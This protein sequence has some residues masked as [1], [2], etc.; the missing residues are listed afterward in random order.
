MRSSFASGGGL[1]LTKTP[2]VRQLA[3]RRRLMVLCGVIALALVSGVFGALTG[4]S[5]EPLQRAVGPFSF[6]P[7][8]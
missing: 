2:N 1:G 8:Q 5:D 3:S 6:F 4:S 7:T